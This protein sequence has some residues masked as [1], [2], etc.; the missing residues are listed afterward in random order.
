LEE[1][2]AMAERIVRLGLIYPT[3]GGEFEYYQL[4]EKTDYRIRPI[5]VAARLY[6]DDFDHDPPAL[7]RTG[8][9]ESLCLTARSFLPLSPDSV[10]WA[11]TSGSFIDGRAHAD[12]ALGLTKVSLLGSYIEP[13][14]QAFVGFL[15]EFGL[16]LEGV[17][18]LGAPGGRDAFQFNREK[19]LEAA[20]AV[21]KPD[22]QAILIP[23]TAMAC[24]HLVEPLEAELGKPV[25][26]ANQVTIWE[27]LRLAKALEPLEG[28]GRL[29]AETA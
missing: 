3:G 16:D 25:L 5:V 11:C 12:Q 23:D 29:F 7:S 4:A 17:V 9:P 10:M 13:T 2:S 20:R 8:Q 26:T 15:G 28:Y 18:A 19:M 6:G 27:G 1:E 21:D 24:L 22:S 14:V